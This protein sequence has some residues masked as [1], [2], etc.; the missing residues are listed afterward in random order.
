MLVADV[1]V[2]FSVKLILEREP[3]RG[4]HDVVENRG[5]GWR[6]IAIVL[7]VLRNAAE[8]GGVHYIQ[9]AIV[10]E[11]VAH[12]AARL[13]D[14]TG[15]CIKLPSCDGTA[16]SRIIDLVGIDR[17]AEGISTGLRPK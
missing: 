3:A 8:I 1:L 9:L 6:Q 4:A 16:R 11:R 2:N 12:S 13:R 15:S 14:E 5:I 7:K 10:D 17:P